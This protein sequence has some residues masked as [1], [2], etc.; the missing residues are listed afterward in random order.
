MIVE[1]DWRDSLKL[2]DV[3]LTKSGTPRVIRRISY[4]KSGILLAVTF[5][6]KRESWTK[7][8]YTVMNRSDLSCLGYRPS[9]VTLKSMSLCDKRLLAD[10]LRGG[11]SSEQRLRPHTVA[12]W[13]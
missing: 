10:I 3:V 5:S 6:I 7:R 1:K 4:R 8:P 12:G 2:G 13:L 9:G 11:P